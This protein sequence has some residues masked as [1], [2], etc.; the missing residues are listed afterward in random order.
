[1]TKLAAGLMQL[2]AALCLAAVVAV[3][4]GT[5]SLLFLFP[6]GAGIAAL[7]LVFAIAEGFGGGAR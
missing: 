7:G 1:M 3:L 6:W 5:G 4:L 2:G